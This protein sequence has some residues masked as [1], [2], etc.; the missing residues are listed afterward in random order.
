MWYMHNIFLF[1]T[2][3]PIVINSQ[4]PAQMVGKIRGENKVIDKE[5]GNT[6][7]SFNWDWTWIGLVGGEKKTK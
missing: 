4:N 2:K 7:G 6:K 5:G 1:H 3:L